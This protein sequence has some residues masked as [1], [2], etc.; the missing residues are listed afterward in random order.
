MRAA[1]FDMDRTVLRVNSGVVWIRH[2]RKAGVMSRM[3]YVRALGWALRY[4]LSLLDMHALS[5]RLAMDSAGDAEDELLERCQSWYEE[6]IAPHVT[7]PARRAIRHHREAGDELVLLT[8]STRYVAGPL[9]RSL[10]FEHVLCSRL[11]VLEG[12]FTGRV[13]ELCF[14]PGKVK[15]AERWADEHGVDLGASTF[16]TDSYSDLPMLERVGQPVV[17]NPDPRLA[18]YAAG[19]HWPVQ[20]WDSPGLAPC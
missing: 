10:G 12:R 7:A 17:I 5:A 6:E 16:Y 14:G 4:K 1:F 18:R 15:A 19:K 13:S 11:E 2:L 3:D 9:G 20:R 8:T